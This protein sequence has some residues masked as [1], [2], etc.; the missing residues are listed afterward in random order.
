M[1]NN[2]NRIKHDR[3]PMFKIFHLASSDPK[4]DRHLNGKDEKYSRI[5]TVTQN[6]ESTTYLSEPMETNM[7]VPNSSIHKR[8]E[9]SSIAVR[10]I[11][12]L[13]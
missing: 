4:T 3:R 1:K 5:A 10:E 8:P 9:R 6:N 11:I 12:T 13:E 2:N 7:P